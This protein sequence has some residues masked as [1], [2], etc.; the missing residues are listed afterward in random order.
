[1]PPRAAEVTTADN[2]SCEVETQVACRILLVSQGG[3]GNV[4]LHAAEVRE[5][6]WPCTL[7]ALEE[8]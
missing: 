5:T 8:P 1:M 6:S 3:V 7:T 2:R 4:L